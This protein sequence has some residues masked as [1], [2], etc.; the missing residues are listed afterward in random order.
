MANL[1]EDQRLLLEYLSMRRVV[2]LRGD[3]AAVAVS[4]GMER[5]IATG[6]AQPSGAIPAQI[7]DEGRAALRGAP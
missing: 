4:P 6:P 2:F 7:T 1:T 5:L 3:D